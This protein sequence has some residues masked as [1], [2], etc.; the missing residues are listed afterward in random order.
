MSYTVCI[1][2]LLASSIIWISFGIVKMCEDTSSY[3]KKHVV[4]TISDVS[5]VFCVI[6]TAP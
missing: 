1:E 4:H 2:S 3:V 5:K 6:L